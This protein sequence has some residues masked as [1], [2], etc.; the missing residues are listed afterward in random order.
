M[1]LRFANAA[2]NRVTSKIMGNAAFSFWI[3][4]A[5][6]E[7]APELDDQLDRRSSRGRSPRSKP[8]ALPF[9][10]RVTGIESTLDPLKSRRQ[11]Q[12]RRG[13]RECARRQKDRRAN[14]AI[15]VIV[16]RILR[17]HLR[18]G[19]RHRGALHDRSMRV[20]RQT[21]QMHVIEGEHGLQRQRDQRQH[22]AVPL[23]ANNP[24]HPQRHPAPPREIAC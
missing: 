9:G 7:L 10:E 24:A 2:A 12:L 14:R 20:L 18:R 19:L 11:R 1:T 5:G 17:R 22:A 3:A 13:R 8:R 4:S 23:M 15:I 21:V 6:V 16:S